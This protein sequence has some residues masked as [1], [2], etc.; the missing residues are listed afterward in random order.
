MIV[1]LLR[2]LRVRCLSVTS[3]VEKKMSENYWWTVHGPFKPWRECPTRPDP[4]EVLLFSLAKRGIGSDE[5][6]DFLSDLLE[7]QKS[8]VYN[9]LKGEGLDTISRCRILVKALKIHPPLLG[10]DARYYPIER[11]A[12]W[13]REQGFAFD[14]DAGGYP[15]IHEVIAYLRVKRMQEGGRN[16]K[17]WT[18]EDLGDATGLKKETVYRMEHDRNPL[19]LDNI[20]RRAMI[21]SALGTLAAE[22]EP[23]LFRLFGL[24]PQAY[25]VP[26]PAS[27]AFLPVYFA[28]RQLTG[29]MLDEYHQKL[30]AFFT[31]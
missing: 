28:T 2:I 20:S 8:M 23:M 7:L 14:A 31:E 11:H 24:D 29:E 15:A 22:N 12:Y 5:Q 27:L 1:V 4:G 16:V 3:L 21:A 19:I 30:A 17:G 6:V 13:W 26:V 25:R 10:I 9:I 18:Q